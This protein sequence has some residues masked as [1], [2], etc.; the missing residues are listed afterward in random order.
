MHARAGL[1][2]GA[3]DACRAR[4]PHNHHHHSNRH[5]QPCPSRGARRARTSEG[6]NAI[7]STTSTSTGTSTAPSWAAPSTGRML[8]ARCTQPGRSPHEALSSRACI[9]TTARVV[10][11]VAAPA[12]A[13][14]LAAQAAQAACAAIRCRQ[15]PR[16]SALCSPHRSA[17]SESANPL[18][19]PG[20]DLSACFFCS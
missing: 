9:P 6:R 13:L 17:E 15:R 4:A 11:D 12:A 1:A 19:A 8:P 10:D 7:P 14:A 5:A 18:C 20:P 2:R 16:P 3:S